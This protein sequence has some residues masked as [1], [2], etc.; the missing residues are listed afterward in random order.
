MSV[1]ISALD[2]T[3]KVLMERL[4]AVGYKGR[5]AVFDDIIRSDDPS[6]PNGFSRG[7]AKQDIP[8]LCKA[9]AREQLNLFLPQIREAIEYPDSG[10]ILEEVL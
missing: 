10:F 1:S 6:G 7:K 9:F 5:F 4:E 8:E 2:G 3:Y